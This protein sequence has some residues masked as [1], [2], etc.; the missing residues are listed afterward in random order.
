MI[1]WS[2]SL[3]NKYWIN[4]CTINS[5]TKS[6]IQPPSAMPKQLFL[7]DVVE[8][9]Q[10]HVVQ[11]L[12]PGCTGHRAM[13]LSKTISPFYLSAHISPTHSRSLVFPSPLGWA[14]PTRSVSSQYDVATTIIVGVQC[15]CVEDQRCSTLQD[16]SVSELSTTQPST[17]HPAPSQC[18]SRWK[19]SLYSSWPWSAM[20]ATQC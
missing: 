4:T 9:A 16:E 13:D 11:A 7:C 1:S 19:L 15:P 17:Y 6:Q 12:L 20:E 14:G 8:P 10:L 2:C 18:S 3:N 5:P